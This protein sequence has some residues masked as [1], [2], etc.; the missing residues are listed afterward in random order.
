MK[1]V[2][3]FWINLLLILLVVETKCLQTLVPCR[4]MRTRAFSVTSPSSSTLSKV[5]QQLVCRHE[6]MELEDEESSL[7]ATE[8]KLLFIARRLKLEVL[9]L[10]EGIYGYD[11]QDNRYGLE[12]VHS[13]ITD[14]TGDGLGIGLTE[15]AASASRD[16]RGLVLISDVVGPALD[17]D[18]TLR[19]GDVLTGVSTEGFRERL[20]GLDYDRTVEVIGRAKQVAAEAASKK[21]EKS[22]GYIRFEADRLVEHGLLSL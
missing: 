12:V 8:E 13:N 6:S 15:V 11:S 5:K 17:T 20:T 19:V 2:Q 9:D 18:C 10:D 16:G 7:S 21:G 3:S 14:K 1:S 4:K 22:P